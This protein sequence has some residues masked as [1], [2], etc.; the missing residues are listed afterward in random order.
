MKKQLLISSLAAL[1]ILGGTLTIILN[2]ASAQKSQNNT[3]AQTSTLTNN[4]ILSTSKNET[5]YIITDE[6][7]ETKTKFIGNTIYTGT[8]ELPFTFKITYFLDGNEISAK[9]LAGKSGHVKIVYAYDSTAKYL[10]KKVPFIAL[11]GLTLDHNSF[12][13]LKL[14]NGKIITE[15]TDNYIIAGYAIT[16]LNTNLGTDFLPDSFTLEADVNNFK[17]ADSYTIFTNELLADIDTSK[18]NSLDSLISSIHQLSDALDQI[19]AGATDLSKGLGTALDGTKQ[20]YAGAQTLSTNLN[21]ATEGASDLSN[22]LTHLSSFNTALTTGADEIF[23]GVLTST[24]TILTTKI[25]AFVPDFSITLTKANYKNQLNHVKSMIPEAHPAR[26]ALIE[27]LDNT[28]AK[29]QKVEFFCTKL[30]TYTSG[31]ADATHGA[32][33]LSDSLTKLSAGASTISDNLGSLVEGTEKLYTGSITLKDGLNTFKTSGI[34]K[35]VN[36]A[37]KDL[38]NFIKN[39]RSSVSAASSYKKFGDTDSKSVKFIVKTPS[40]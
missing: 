22:G 35:L 7:G 14:T 38:N 2:D 6:S 19:I 32:S 13:N 25:S 18:L 21:A 12:S 8:E 37:S 9:D 20:L 1:G 28:S 16:G 40:I 27:T 3:L 24:S 30:A 4:N 31:V 39:V 26:P 5:V 34:D 29:L 11:T 15:G 10:G 33:E 36:F 17:L 23:D